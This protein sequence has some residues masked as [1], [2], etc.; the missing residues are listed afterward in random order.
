MQTTASRPLR[1]TNLAPGGGQVELVPAAHD[2]GRGAVHAVL[3][4]E[5]ADDFV[6]AGQRGFAEAQRAAGGGGVGRVE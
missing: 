3:V 6:P 4:E 1:S 5:Q 2:V